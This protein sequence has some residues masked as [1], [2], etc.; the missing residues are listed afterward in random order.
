[1]AYLKNEELKFLIELKNDLAKEENLS[2]KTENL[3]KLIERHLAENK[4]TNTKT[5]K[6]IKQKRLIDKSYGR[7]KKKAK[8]N[9]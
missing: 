4:K 2:P 9:Q 6:L 1:M 7:S 3:C 8:E 5:W